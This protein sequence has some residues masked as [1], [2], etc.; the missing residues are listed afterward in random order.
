MKNKSSYLYYKIYNDIITKIKDGTL[1]AGD[2]IEKEIVL[3]EKYQISRETMRKALDYLCKMNL[4]YRIKKS[5]TFINGKLNFKNMPKL[6]ATVLPFTEN[7]HSELINGIQTNAIARNVFSPIYNSYSNVE[8]EREILESLLNMTIDGLI[9]YPCVGMKNL[10]ILY[11]FKSK[12]IPIV[13][14]DRRIPSIDAPL[15]TSDN[16]SGVRTMVDYL[17][18][19]G[20]KKIAFFAINQNLILPEKDRLQGYLETIAKHNLPINNEYIFSLGTLVDKLGDFT[21][22]KQDNY[23][24]YVIKKNIERFLSLKDLPTA[25]VC[26]NDYLAINFMKIVKSKNPEISFPENISITGFDN[27]PIGSS[28]TPS[29]TTVSQNFFQIGKIAVETAIDML[30]GIPIKNE[31]YIETKLIIRESTKSII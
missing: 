5:G 23:Y 4:I 17:I 16:K 30:N 28:F 21:A 19:L 29:L 8:H 14:I 25:V 27:V 3:A 18:S 22:K 2:K 10:D 9:I 20:H 11:K 26:L 31:T 6:V 12:N 1:K 13:F 24:N 7:L 15:I